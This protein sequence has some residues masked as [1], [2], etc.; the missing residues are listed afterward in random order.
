MNGNPVYGSNM[1]VIDAAQRTL[2]L[3][4][5]LGATRIVRV[6]PLGAPIAVAPSSTVPTVSTAIPVQWRE[7][8]VVLAAYGQERTG[9]V[10]KFASTEARI[11]ISGSEDLISDGTNGTFMPFLA[12]FGP[13]VNWFP[14]TRKV[15]SGVNWTV[16]YRNTD[17]AAVCNPDLIFAF[18]AEA[19]LA[20]MKR[21]Q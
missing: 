21:T 6:A 13:N 7:D 14:F 16:T 12:M 5:R 3:Y 18:I 11:Q 15:R 2:A 4:G 9:T 8:G 20:K 10:A 19:D 1:S 17:T